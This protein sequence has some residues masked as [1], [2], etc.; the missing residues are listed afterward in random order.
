M[1]LYTEAHRNLFSFFNP[2]HIF[3]VSMTGS[4]VY[5]V[6]DMHPVTEIDEIRQLKYP[7]PYY[8][9][10]FKIMSSEFFNRRIINDNRTVAQHT[11][12]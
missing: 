7:V 3:N 9:F 11:G 1:A 6:Y 12:L 8:R 2:V 10:V 4:A 5:P